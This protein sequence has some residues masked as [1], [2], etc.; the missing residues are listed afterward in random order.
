MYREIDKCQMSTCDPTDTTEIGIRKVH[1]NQRRIRRVPK[2]KFRGEFQIPEDAFH[3]LP[4]GGARRSLIPRAEADAELD[5]RSR[6]RQVQER[7]NHAPV[8]LLVH[9]LAVEVLIKRHRCADR[10][11]LRRQVTHV[12]LPKQ[13]SSVLGLM[14]E[15]ALRSLLDLQPEEEL[16]LA[17]HAHL[18]LTGHLLRK[19]VD[20]S[21]RRATKDNIIHVYL[22]QKEISARSHEEQTFINTSHFKAL[23]Q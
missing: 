15:S 7:A 21:V 8:L 12:E 2:T 9:R 1:Q 14:D 23:S 6:R 17:H 5:V 18:E 16:Q 11:R 22:N 3:H 13:V 10:R 19:L 20:K 4:V